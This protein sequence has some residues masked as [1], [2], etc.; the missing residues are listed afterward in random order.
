MEKSV[1]KLFINPL[2]NILLFGNLQILFMKRLLLLVVLA[3]YCAS[4]S[5]QEVRTIQ[6]SQLME[7]NSYLNYLRTSE[8]GSRTSVSNSNRLE[9]LLNEV[10]PALYFHSGNLKEYGENPTSL[11]TDSS[12]L[13]NITLSIAHKKTIEIVTIKLNQNLD[14]SNPMDLTVFSSFPNLKYIY[15]LSTVETSGSVISGLV[16]NNNA[17]FGVFYKVDKGS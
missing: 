2:N 3:F 11:Y 10:Q 12:S 5:A 17:R 7:V 13:N 6:S 4:T 9:Q 1:P 8:V 16:K 14:L 15:I